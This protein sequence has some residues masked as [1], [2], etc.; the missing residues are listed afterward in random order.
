MRE[1]LWLLVAQGMLGA[2]DT[3]Y[4]HEYRARLAARV[5]ARAELFL[6]AARDFVYAFIFGLLARF[7]WRGAWAWLLAVLLFVEIGIT[8]ADFVVEDRV[9][10]P[11]GGVFPGERVTHAIMGIIYGGFLACL[12]PDWLAWARAPTE[13][14]TPREAVSP[15]L[16]L[17][18][19]VMAAGVFASGLRDLYAALGF[20]G[21]GFPWSAPRRDERG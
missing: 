6:H 9:R 11:Q 16:H 12:S 20:P 2:F 3:L 5:E 4:Y 8:L 7:E 15:W 13:L 1:A 18:L 19:G 10:R 14:A 21:G 17:I